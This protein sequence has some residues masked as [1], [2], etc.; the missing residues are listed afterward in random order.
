MDIKGSRAVVTGGASGIG[1]AMVEEL[2]ARGARVVVADIDG[3]RARRVA[4]QHPGASGARCDV[5][6]HA[7]VE[8]LCDHAYR[9]LGGVDLVF[10]NAGVNLSGP[11]LKA[12]PQEL[13]WVF[14][15]NVRGIWSTLSIFANRMIEAGH[16][17]RICVTASEHAL[18]LQHLGAGLYTASKQAVL[19][20]ADVFA[21]ELPPSVGLSVFCP[22]LVATE[23]HLSRRHSPFPAADPADLAF[24]A[25]ILARGMPASEA[26][27]AAIDAVMRGDPLIVSHST[28]VTAA[29][30]RAEHVEAAFAAQAPWTDDGERYNVNNV[31][32]AVMSENEARRA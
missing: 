28:S 19:G 12:T 18:G 1:L 16:P 8:A 11:L 23:L 25:A 15:V 17:G 14:G 6:V 7:E 3:D 27:R 13:D 9:E 22:G 31:I 4:E 32:A 20:L 5:S 26:A 21:A 24:S 30:K 10:A 2:L 29:R